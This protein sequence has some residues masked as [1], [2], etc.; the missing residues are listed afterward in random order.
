MKFD[1]TAIFS[2]F[3]V[4]FAIIDVI[5]SVPIFLG[6]KKQNRAIDPEKAAFYALLVMVV[7]Y[8]VGD[9]ILR[10]FGVDKSSFAV[11]G[12]LV[13]FVVAIELTFGIE[14]FKNDSPSGSATIVPVVFPLLTGPG[15]FTGLLSLRAEYDTF[16][17]LTAV[18]LNV[19]VIYLALKKMHVVERIFG[20]GGIYILRKFFGII[21]L[22]I[23]VK[24]FASNITA[25]LN[26]FAVNP[27]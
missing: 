27:Q 24:L 1:I 5:G 25:L 6:L 8:F 13:L 18:V 16:T 4:L 26:S 12:A 22:A 2:S 9:W 7:F 10:V 15:V 11:A 17:I 14:I 21:L 3:L 19:L 20:Q 23:S